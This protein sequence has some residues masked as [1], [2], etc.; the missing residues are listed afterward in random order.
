MCVYGMVLMLL[1]FSGLA[2]LFRC[3]ENA[4]WLILAGALLFTFSDSIIALE[5][6]S[7]EPISWAPA[8]IMATYLTAQSLL[9][10]GALHI[11]SSK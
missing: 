9:A 6:F 1:I 10:I 8:T 4:W 11:K 2:G 5:T 7:E 3:R